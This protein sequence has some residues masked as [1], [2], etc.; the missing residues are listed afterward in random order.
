MDYSVI[1]DRHTMPIY[2]D[3]LV[4]IDAQSIRRSQGAD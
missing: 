2:H 4:K 3:G 1:G